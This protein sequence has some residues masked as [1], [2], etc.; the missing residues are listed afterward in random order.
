MIITTT[1]QPS[2]SVC[3]T[4]RNILVALLLSIF[5][6]TNANASHL[7]GGDITYKEIKRHVYDVTVTLFRDC[8]GV[9]LSSEYL[10]VQ[11]LGVLKSTYTLT[12]TSHSTIPF[13]R[14][15]KTRCEDTSVRWP[16]GYEKHILKCKVDLSSYVLSGNYIFSWDDCCRN[17]AITTGASSENFHIETLLNVNDS[18]SSPEFVNEPVYMVSGINKTQTVSMLAKDVDG[19]SLV[20]HLVHPLQYASNSFGR[21]TYVTYNNGYSYLLP[22]KGTGIKLDS[23]TGDF[24]FKATNLDITQLA[25]QVD[26][27]RKISGVATKMGSV[28]RDIQIV[29]ISDS[30][31][32]NPVTGALSVNKNPELSG[33]DSTSAYSIHIK[34]KKTTCFTIY[35]TDKDSGD[36]SFIAV[37]GGITG[38]S[39]TVNN[40]LNQTLSFCWTP[41]NAD[42][43]TIPYTFAVN[44]M[45]NNCPLAG[46]SSHSYQVYVDYVP[47]MDTITGIISTS[48]HHAL[49]N[50]KV[51][52]LKYD[53]VDTTINAID[54]AVTDTSG[55]YSFY[56]L[57]SSNLFI[58]ALEY[59]TYYDSSVVFQDADTIHVMKFGKMN[60]SFHTLSGSN[61]GGSGFIGGKVIA[62]LICKKSGTGMPIEGLKVV[63]MDSNNK[64]Q[65]YTYTDK[66][67]EFTFKNLS[68]QKYKVWVDKQRVDNSV[69]PVIT[70]FTRV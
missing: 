1:F 56:T 34:A 19:D 38:A 36:S 4:V 42:A 28:I 22:F 30:N 51:L 31:R 66:N 32:T 15:G 68:I 52:L 10:S 35:S 26:E 12:E 24:T 64:P 45:D 7:A 61:P 57:D 11:G 14:H 70:G 69:A 47:D 55:R 50:S 18:N 3:P 27:W 63:L 44:A 25:V 65:G 17:L 40:G 41:T 53:A 20:Y 58:I 43:S 67:G 59:P 9:A 46:R 2:K 8:N 62:C 29:L 23:F 48:T 21:G 54:T 16:Y 60:I 39:F 33:F 49:K 13:C 5:S 37:T 6:F